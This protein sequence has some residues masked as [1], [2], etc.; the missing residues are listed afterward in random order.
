MTT[1]R[2]REA[3]PAYDPERRTPGHAAGLRRR[4]QPRAGHHRPR[5]LGRCCSQGRV[6]C[7][8]PPLRR[9]RCA[10]TQSGCGDHRRGRA[11]RQLLHEQHAGLRDRHGRPLRRPDRRPRSGWASR[12]TTVPGRRRRCR[13]GW[14]RE[15]MQTVDV[16]YAEEWKFDHGIMVPLH[17][18]D[19]RRSTRKVIPV[20]INCQGP[21]L[22][23]LHRAVGL[24]RSAAPRLRRRYPNALRWWAPAASRTG[25][26]RQTRARSTRRGTGSSWTTGV[27]TTAT[28]MLNDGPLQ[29]RGHLPRSGPGRL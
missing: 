8:V 22:T 29:R 4:V 9:R 25:R 21:P 24:R 28:R 3:W 5:A 16:A 10:L 2:R 20:N 27:P 13:S 18:P 6:P 15:V 14:S 7:A 12:K 11:L 23:P 26:P 19:T 17:F 1:A